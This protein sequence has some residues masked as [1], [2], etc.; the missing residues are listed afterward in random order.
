M[1]NEDIIINRPDLLKSSQ[2]YTA[3]GLT[4]FFWG[5]LIYLWQPAI[6]L[7]AWA[8]NL[9]IFYEHMVVL[10]GYRTFL[11]LLVNYIIVI[12]VLVGAL[13]LWARVNQW[14]FRGVE[15]RVGIEKTDIDAVCATFSVNRDSVELWRSCSNLIVDVDE[16]GLVSEVVVVESGLEV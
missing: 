3:L 8:F 6:S 12:S 10:G 7:L 5:A 16:E 2:K 4:L 1:K 15:R 9:N 14:R 13:L 11:N